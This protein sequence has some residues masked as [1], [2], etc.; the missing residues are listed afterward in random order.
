[1]KAAIRYS[2][3]AT[4]AVALAVGMVFLYR[5]VRQQTTQ[6]VCGRLDVHFADSLRFVSEQDIRDYLDS[7]YGAY[8]GERMDSVQLARIEDMIESRSAVSRCEAWATDDGVLHLEVTPRAPVLRFMRSEQDGFYVDGQG[9][10]FPLHPSYTAAVPVVEG[11]IPVDVPADYKGE[12]R[13]ERERAWI[14]GVLAMNRHIAANRAWQR[15]IAHIRVRP[16]GELLLSLTGREEEF[17]VGQPQD[18]PDKLQR[19][20]RY[21][22]VIAPSKPEGY[23]H[24]VNVKYKQQII[25]R[26]KD[27]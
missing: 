25:C 26:Q 1:M 27:T 21:L 19:I 15:R 6:I 17:F 16:G 20:D 13:D 22:G 10:I 14:A 3:A 8:I 4:L 5:T 11:A 18:I 9:Y 2:L 12:A 24:T 7:R 23:Y